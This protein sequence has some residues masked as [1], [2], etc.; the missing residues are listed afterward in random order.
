MTSEEIEQNFTGI[1]YIRY[2]TDVNINLKHQIS[3]C[4]AV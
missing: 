4:M 1:K 2:V 3:A